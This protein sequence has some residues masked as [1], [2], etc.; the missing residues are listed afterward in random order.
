MEEEIHYT[1]EEGDNIWNIANHYNTT[2]D[3]ILQL[4]PQIADETK[5][6]IGEEITLVAPEPVLGV[7]STEIAIFQEKIPAEIEYVENEDMY[8]DDTKVIQEGNDGIKEI[9]VRLEMV[10]S[11]EISREIIEENVLL[12]PNIEIVEF[13]TKERPKTTTS[14]SSSASSSVTS[15]TSGMF[16]HP[17]NGNGSFS[18]GYGT[19]WGSFHG[20]V[21]IS[22]PAGTAVYA[23]AAGTVTYSGY[24]GGYGN[25]VIIDHG[26]GYETYYAHNS[27][28][29]VQVGQT[30]TKGQNIAA[31]G[32]TGYSTGN[33]VHFEIRI[34]GQRV[35]PYGYLF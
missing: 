12:E 2:M 7:K 29:Y 17:L 1:L 31:V 19:R 23:S 13:G 26:N 5:M 24:N 9:V 28:N 18:S 11:V 35:N 6:Q 3:Q 21:D 27:R 25:L 32:S 22:A 14:T 4:N 20:G 16:M 34:N 30:V 15:N 10:N 8:K 33:H